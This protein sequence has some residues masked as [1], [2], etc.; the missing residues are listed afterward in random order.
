MSSAKL[1]LDMDGVLFNFVKGACI[2]H[3]RPNPYDNFKNRGI[4]DM[5]KIWGMTP[6]EFWKP[7][8]EPGFFENLELE[9]N[10]HSLVNM[11]Y[12]YFSV[13]NICIL[14]SPS[15]GVTCVTEKRNAIYKYFKPLAKNML[16]GSAKRFL[17]GDPNRILID[18]R[19]ENILDWRAHGGT[20]ILY[21]QPWN[22]LCEIA[23][24]S[25]V[26]YVRRKIELL[27]SYE[28]SGR[29]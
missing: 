26:T 20:G 29:S 11:L 23:P 24:I 21:P 15:M 25:N 19:E 13:D 7:L 27:P 3:N 8:S 12:G 14:S 6:Q 17:S 2:A 5:D 22:G 4:F 16:F 18:D 1:F 9:P 28:Q 10:A